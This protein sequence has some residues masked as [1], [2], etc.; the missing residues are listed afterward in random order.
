MSVFTYSNKS[1]YRAHCQAFTALLSGLLNTHSWFL[2][3]SY[4]PAG[5]WTVL[6]ATDGILSSWRDR[7]PAIILWYPGN[8]HIILRTNAHM[9]IKVGFRW[10]WRWMLKKNNWLNLFYLIENDFMIL[11]FIILKNFRASNEFHSSDHQFLLENVLLVFQ[12]AVLK[13]NMTSYTTSA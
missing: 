5:I 7:T 1:T 11:D 12:R 4:M 6:S 3:S 2:N 10:W 9:K 8:Q 13:G